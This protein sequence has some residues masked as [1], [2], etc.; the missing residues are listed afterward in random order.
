MPRFSVDK[1]KG[2][3]SVM[4]GLQELCSIDV[5]RMS[6]RPLTRHDN[7]WKEQFNVQVSVSVR[8]SESDFYQ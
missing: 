7:I 1:G 5:V 6:H 8:R 2:R 3:N 4:I